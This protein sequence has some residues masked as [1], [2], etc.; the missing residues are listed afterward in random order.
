MMVAR[1]SSLFFMDDPPLYW[2]CGEP[3]KKKAANI[4]CPFN[5]KWNGAASIALHN[6]DNRRH[7]LPQTNPQ[8]PER[9]LRISAMF[10]FSR[11]FPRHDRDTIQQR[12][13]IIYIPIIWDLC[14]N[15][16]GNSGVDCINSVFEANKK[17][18]RYFTACM[19][20]GAAWKCYTAVRSIFKEYSHVTQ[21][22]Q[23]DGGK[24]LA[25]DVSIQC[26]A[27]VF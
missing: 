5:S 10:P 20:D 24:S 22:N 19:I 16:K 27:D 2:G 11:A 14:G 8:N 18:G 1:M 6:C 7:F 12:A 26:A 17:S 3:E 13:S 15:C 23:H 25:A 9:S 4:R 21:G